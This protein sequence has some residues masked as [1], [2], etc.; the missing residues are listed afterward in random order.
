MGKNVR[1]FVI[2][3][4]NLREL[5]ELNGIY[6]VID[7]FDGEK[8]EYRYAKCDEFYAVW[9]N[10]NLQVAKEDLIYYFDREKC[11]ASIEKGNRLFKVRTSREGGM[12]CSK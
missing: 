1:L 10:R 9:D 12:M 7:H 11:R 8:H 4:E 6:P 2:S 5:L 3:Q